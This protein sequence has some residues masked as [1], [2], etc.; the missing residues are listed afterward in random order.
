[1]WCDLI[2][3]LSVIIF[4]EWRGTRSFIGIREESCS[5]S[6]SGN[7]QEVIHRP[8]R[9]AKGTDTCSLVYMQ[10]RK[11]GYLVYLFWSNK[12]GPPPGRALKKVYWSLGIEECK[13][14][15]LG[16]SQVVLAASSLTPGL[17]SQLRGVEPPPKSQILSSWSHG[18][19]C[20][21]VLS[22]GCSRNLCRPVLLGSL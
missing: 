7:L 1:M 20:A 14:L 9:A 10:G 3:T 18:Q 4:W 19:L 5:H 12:D 22:L 17:K 11:N 8:F 15:D 16:M 21:F 6:H 2:A 13:E